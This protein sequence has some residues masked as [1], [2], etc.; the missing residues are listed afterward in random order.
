MPDGFLLIEF[1]HPAKAIDRDA[2]NQEVKYRDDLIRYY[3]PIHILMLG[4]GRAA[5]V[6]PRT[7]PPD[8]VVVSYVS[9][10][11]TARTQLETLLRELRDSRLPPLPVGAEVTASA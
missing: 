4:S 11:S 3:Q 6:D 5:T 10:I 8:L 2:E 9:L 1:K 7:G